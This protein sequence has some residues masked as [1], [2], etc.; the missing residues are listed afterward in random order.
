MNTFNRTL[1]IATLALATVGAHA[2]PAQTNATVSAVGSV[3]QSASYITTKDG[4]QLYYKDWG[5]RNGQVVTFSHGWP[6]DS[7]SWEAQ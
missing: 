7:D 2:A 6:L 3:V 4:V 1:A 5:P